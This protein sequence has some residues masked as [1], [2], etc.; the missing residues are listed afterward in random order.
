MLTSSAL[1]WNAQDELK[2]H[3]G[4]VYLCTVRFDEIETT[5]TRDERFSG[6][7]LVGR[8]QVTVC[9]VVT[10][11]CDVE[12]YRR[13]GGPCCLHLHWVVTSCCDVEGY[14]RFVGPCCLHLH[15]VV[16]SCSVVVGY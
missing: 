3:L 14:Q 15:W 13:F 9:W 7:K 10:S 1:C 16:T 6:T 4:Q 2:Q 12:G 5:L 11:C 8:T